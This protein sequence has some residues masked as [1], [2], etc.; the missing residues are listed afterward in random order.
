[1]AKNWSRA[2][3]NLLSNKVKEWSE[4][5][6]PLNMEYLSRILKRSE[7]A[8]YLKA[9]RM[10]LPLRAQCAR[11]TMRRIMESKFGDITLFAANRQ[12]YQATGISQKR[13]PSLLYGY[14]E[15]TQDEI[16]RVAAYLHI[17]QRDWIRLVG[18]YQ[19]SLFD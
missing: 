12:F 8:I 1:M 6:M 13:W 10:R 4:K 3:E 15:P 16:E 5:G 17:D 14:D 11:P 19:L 9:Y 2:D 7:E 18:E